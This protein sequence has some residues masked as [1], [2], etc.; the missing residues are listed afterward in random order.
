MGV[1]AIDHVLYEKLVKLA[2]DRS[3]ATYGDV[4]SLIG[5]DIVLDAGREEIARRLGDIVVYEH[6]QGRPML[7]A[8]VVHKG[9][10]NNPGGAL[11]S[12]AEKIRFFLWL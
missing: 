9:G 5:L 7:T 3:L 4:A 8:F 11:F 1:I 6:A 12:D 10:D 2:I